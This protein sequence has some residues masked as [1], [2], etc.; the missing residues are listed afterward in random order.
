MKINRV[1]ILIIVVLKS[2]FL[3]AQTEY[4]PT[5]INPFGKPNQKAPVEIKDY[6]AL[7]GI[8]DCNSYKIGKDNNWLLP[9]KMTWEF[10]YIM[11]GMAVQDETLKE[12][13]IHSGSI[14]QF[15]ADSSAWYVHY[16]TTAIS[17]P[18]LRTWKGGK[19]ADKI[20]LYSD[21]KS[22][23]GLD[24]YYKISFVDITDEGFNWLGE[25]VNK[26]ESIIFPT[27]KIE[28]K[29]RDNN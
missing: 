9:V 12:D 22:P 10:K 1:F 3:I 7:I 29:K 11:N 23:N 2:S 21:Q 15:N 4:G 16:Y 13:G 19:T 17:S 14:R 8:C 25:W 20:I 28:C 18:S 26:D 5:S 24:G 6:Q 27:W